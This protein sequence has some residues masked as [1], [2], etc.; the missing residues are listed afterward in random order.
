MLES[1]FQSELIKELRELLPGSVVLKNDAH[2][3]QGFPDLT[4]LYKN[5]WALL[6][7]KRSAKEKYQP[8]Q[9]HYLKEMDRLSFARTIHPENKEV[10]LDALQR[11]LQ[12]SGATRIPKSK[13][14]PLD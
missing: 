6:E 9:E 12:P 11:S 7:C 14:V 3:I 4:V 8:N 2:Y 1:K 10:V 13:Q 5:K